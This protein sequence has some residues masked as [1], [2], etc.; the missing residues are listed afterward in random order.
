MIQHGFYSFEF[1]SMPFGE[2]L[3]RWRGALY[4][5]R[6]PFL[7]LY[8]DLAREGPA[9][10]PR[11]RQRMAASSKGGALP[12]E[13]HQAAFERLR[14]GNR[15]LA[16]FMAYVGKRSPHRPSYRTA[17][18]LRPAS[19]AYSSS[20]SAPTNKRPSSFEATPLVPDPQNGSKTRSPSLLDARMARRTRRRG[21]WVG[22]YP[23][24]FS[25]F[26]TEGM[27]QTEES[28]AS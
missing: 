8:T 9:R 22:W 14:G 25:L 13:T 10:S 23:W 15:K 6:E 18:I 7:V 17:P 2:S 4:A 3:T 27:C 16:I 1:G 20:C 19:C 5:A 12:G 21:F 11:T 28:W 24:S 26:G